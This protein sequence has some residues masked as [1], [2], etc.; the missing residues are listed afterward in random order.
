MISLAAALRSSLHSPVANHA[1][2]EQHT[3]QPQHAQECIQTV[4]EFL[5]SAKLD[6]IN[7]FKLVRCS[8]S[9]FLNMCFVCCTS[10]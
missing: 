6:G 3:R 9:Y 5:F 2:Q 7:M 4:N 10:A 1:Q 8:L